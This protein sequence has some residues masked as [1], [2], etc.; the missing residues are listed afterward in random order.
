[1]GNRSVV[2]LMVMMFACIIAIVI[3]G[4]GTVIVF[5]EVRDPET[6]TALL[7]HTLMGLVSGIL[8]ALLGLVAGRG[9][10]N[11]GGNADLHKRPDDTSNGL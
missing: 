8:G 3:L 4:L 5:L 1:M 9:S 7:S 2:E 10:V 11:G 6:D